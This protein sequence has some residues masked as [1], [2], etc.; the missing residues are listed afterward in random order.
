LR[1]IK[2]PV[3]FSRCSATTPLFNSLLTRILRDC[4]DLAL[5]ICSLKVRTSWRNNAVLPKSAASG[6][7]SGVTESTY[8]VAHLV[9][10]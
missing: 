10:D 3:L 9:A 2:W 1:S 6:G 7:A 4:A 5:P 8:P